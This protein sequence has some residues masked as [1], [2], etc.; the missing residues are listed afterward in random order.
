MV[1][2]KQ[3]IENF[4][5]VVAYNLYP[6][7]SVLPQKTAKHFYQPSFLPLYVHFPQENFQNA[8]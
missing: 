4:Y 5:S 2:R 8:V 6:V 3:I 1:A 7:S